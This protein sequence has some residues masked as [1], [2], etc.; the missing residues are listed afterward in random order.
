MEFGLEKW[1]MQK[2]KSG[3]KET[4]E[5][6]EQPNK[7]ST[8]TLEKKENYECLRLVEVVTRKQA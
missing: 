7:K 6:I 2:M 8:R 3:K 1:A 4:T 5:G